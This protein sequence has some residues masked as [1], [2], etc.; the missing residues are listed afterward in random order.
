MCVRVYVGTESR[1]SHVAR[2]MLQNVVFMPSIKKSING[3]GVIDATALVPCRL[4]QQRV[5]KMSRA[6]RAVRCVRERAARDACEK[7]EHAR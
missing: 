4:T 3:L 2:R 1:M 5:P 6:N 7:L